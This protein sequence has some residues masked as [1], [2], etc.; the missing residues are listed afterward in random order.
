MKV[1]HARASVGCKMSDKVLKAP[2]EISNKPED[3][4]W[5]LDEADTSLASRVMARCGAIAMVSVETD[6]SPVGPTFQGRSK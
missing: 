2:D 6:K 4:E 5:L 3:S 1:P